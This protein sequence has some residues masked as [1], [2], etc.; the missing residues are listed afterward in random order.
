MNRLAVVLAADSATTVTYWGEN[1]REERYF[2][3]ANKIFQLSA[4][5]PIGV[6]IF[7]SA[8]LL[9]VPWEVVIKD[10][11]KNLGEKSFNAVAGYATEFF[12]YINGNTV[13]FP[14]KVQR[15]AFI[16]AVQSVIFATMH[17]AR[18]EN[19][20]KRAMDD[21]MAAADA[22]LQKIDLL[23][24]IDPKALDDSIEAA[25]DELVEYARRL[26]DAFK[27]P[28]PIDVA[29]FVE[30][31]ITDV[32]KRPANR[33]STAGLVFAGFGD[34]DIFPSMS[35]FTSC[36]MLACK[37]VHIVGDHI[38]IDHETPAWLA[39]FAQRNMADTFST[40][41]SFDVYKST[42][43]AVVGGLAAFAEKLA[44]AAGFDPANIAPLPDLL[45]E[46]RGQ[47]GD[48][49]LERAR[50]EHAIPMRRVLGALPVDE[51]AELAETLI[52]LQSLKEKVTKPS[53]SVGGP[54][55]VAAITRSEGLVWIKRKHYFDPAINSRYMARQ[56]TT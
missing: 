3:G 20:P 46:A 1:G 50:K 40:G 39:P 26:L 52:N 11:R 4:H 14:P 13:M 25:R 51:L 35:S 47:I 48:S 55:D 29:R 41:V 38:S 15:E 42:M 33:M 36:C 22:D 54:V 37:H 32:F 17:T 2:K 6:M 28:E 45:A 16:D 5:H 18:D 56:Q 9:K 44:Q 34:H 31:A 23:P 10:F 27:L 24:C 12:E 53:A 19:D 21:A 49:V 30:L 7:D 8:D 43:D